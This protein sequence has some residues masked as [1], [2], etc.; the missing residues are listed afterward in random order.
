[1]P[2]CR[3]LDLSNCRGVGSEA[4]RAALA[5][6]PSFPQ[7]HTLRLQGLQELSDALLADIVL[8]L[9]QL[10]CLDLYRCAAITDAGL[11]GVAAACSHRLTG[12]VLDDVARVTDRG[13]LAVAEACMVLEVRRWGVLAWHLC[14]A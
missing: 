12:L 11:R 4:L 5:C 10:R 2:I 6:P 14:E 9:P 13:L 1:M 7:L 8:A 3:V